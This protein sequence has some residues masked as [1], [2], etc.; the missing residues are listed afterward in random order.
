MFKK[1]KNA[2]PVMSKGIERAVHNQLIEHLEKQK[3]IFDCTSLV[4]EA[5]IL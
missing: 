4:L 3:I 1:G 2:E 5:N